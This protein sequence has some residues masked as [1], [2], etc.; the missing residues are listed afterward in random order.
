[1]TINYGAKWIKF[2]ADGRIYYWSPQTK[3]VITEQG[4]LRATDCYNLEEA[5]KRVK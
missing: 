2:H 3:Q 5:R 4:R 1:M